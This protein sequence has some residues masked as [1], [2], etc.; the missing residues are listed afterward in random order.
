[1]VLDA[2]LSLTLLALAGAGLATGLSVRVAVQSLP[3]RLVALVDALEGQVVR[4]ETE[5]SATKLH[6]VAVE[7]ELQ[8]LVESVERKRRR[9]AASASKVA[10]SFDNGAE[11]EADPKMALRRRAGLAG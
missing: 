1:M 8:G 6:L 10:Q 4:V 11:E 7:E 5:W 9:T 2:N 3:G